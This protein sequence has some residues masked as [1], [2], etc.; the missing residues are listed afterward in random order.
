MVSRKN[1]VTG[2]N[3]T[4]KIDVMVIPVNAR[5]TVCK[6]LDLEPKKLSKIK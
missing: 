6:I 5:A 2:A 3:P 1:K 4:N